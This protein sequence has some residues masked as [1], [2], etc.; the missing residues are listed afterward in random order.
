MKLFVVESPLQLINAKEAQQHFEIEQMES[1]LL[2]LQGVSSLSQQQTLSLARRE[3]WLS[4][5]QVGSVKTLPAFWVAN[6]KIRHWLKQWR[7]KVDGVIIGDFRSRFM[8]HIANSI[9]KQVILIDD[10]A[11]T[12]TVADQRCKNVSLDQKYC[13]GWRRYINKRNILGYQDHDVS[14]LTF[15]TAFQFKVPNQDNV[16][17][18]HYAHLRQSMAAYNRIPV[19]YFVGCPLVE[20]GMISG[21]DYQAYLEKIASHFEE[22]ICYIPH[23]RENSRRVNSLAASLKWR[24]ETFDKPLEIELLERG[25]LP[26]G[27]IGLYST[28]LNNVYTLFG[29][30]LPICSYQIPGEDVLIPERR[31]NVARVYDYYHRHCAGDTFRVR[32]LCLKAERNEK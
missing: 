21:A 8:R 9:G 3:D 24:V 22:P 15:F 11:A 6:R 31:E 30:R 5:K 28:A 13:R 25:E 7:E 23:R 18:H 17:R 1:L 14:S 29:E 4:I 12:L 26:L 16:V 20:M 27:L 32:P 19:R 2:V 10:G